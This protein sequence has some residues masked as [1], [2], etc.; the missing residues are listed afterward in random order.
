[1]HLQAGLAP[2]GRKQP[3]DGALGADF[4]PTGKNALKFHN[5]YSPRHVTSLRIEGPLGRRHG[6]GSIPAPEGA[7]WARSLLPC[8]EMPTTPGA[9]VTGV[10][11]TQRDGVFGRKRPSAALSGKTRDV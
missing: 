3:Q 11:S 10:G 8:R 6:A 5:Y 4:V 7:G 9:R 1:M 2:F